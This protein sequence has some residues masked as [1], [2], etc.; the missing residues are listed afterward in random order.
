MDK[1]LAELQQRL[2]SSISIQWCR[3]LSN[4]IN[5]LSS[6]LSNILPIYHTRIARDQLLTSI[7]LI[8]ELEINS[9]TNELYRRALVNYLLLLSLHTHKLICGIFLDR[10]DHVKKH[11]NYW[12]HHE[13]YPFNIIDQLKTIFWF[14]KDR[15]DIRIT[16]K[17]KFLNIQQEILANIIGRLAYTIT[18]LEQ[19]EQI[20]LDLVM[21]YTNELHK[22]IFDGTT[23]NYNSHSDLSDVIELYSQML[24]NFDDFHLRWIEKVH[25]YSQPTH[26][27]RYFPYYICFTALGVY[28]IYKV[29]TNKDQIINYFYTSYDSLKFFVNE[30]LIA[31]IKT[32]YTSTFE[33]NAYGRQHAQILAGINNISTEEFL[34]TLN[35]RAMNEDMNIVMKFY[36]QEL[37][38]PIRSALLGDLIKG[39]RDDS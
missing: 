31:P 11:S 6:S 26:I 19:Q 33:S 9:Q 17:V 18:N 21:N 36:Q 32:I 1:R 37:N 29:Y 24:I 7:K 5:R 15:D 4:E 13:H 16:E 14:D 12:K 3:T 2:Q 10:I 25:L 23:V 39:I 20:N 8:Q 34:S 22:I 38:S 27:K 28:T 30:H 35:Q